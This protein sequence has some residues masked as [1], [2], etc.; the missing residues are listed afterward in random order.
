MNFLLRILILVITSSQAFAY[1]PNNDQPSVLKANKIDGDR[2]T[3]IVTAIGDV[4]LSN[5]TAVAT[6]DQMSYNKDTGWI[7]AEGNLKIKDLEQLV[8]E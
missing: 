8:S 4:E 1:N 2:N 5:D 3:N 6:S 7:K